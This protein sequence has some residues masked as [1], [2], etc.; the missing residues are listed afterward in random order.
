[1]NKKQIS[2]NFVAEIGCNHQ[3]DLN[4]A[5]KMVDTLV[6]FCKVKYVKFQKRNPM[7]LLGLKRYN[8]PHPIPENSFGETYGL[9]R[10]KLEFSINQ[11]KKI[12]KYCKSKRIEY[13]CSAWD[14]TSL[15]Q[16]ICI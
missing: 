7:E 11:H 5:L 10:E 12:Q 9:H 13:M 2:I 15:K 4:F 1:M 6:D 16:L 8:K 3:G 14:L